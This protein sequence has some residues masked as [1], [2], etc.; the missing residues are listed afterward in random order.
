MAYSGGQFD[1]FVRLLEKLL[2][3]GRVPDA[4]LLSGRGTTSRATRY[5]R[6]SPQDRALVG[7][8]ERQV[9]SGRRDDDHGLPGCVPIRAPKLSGLPVMR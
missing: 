2:R 1:D 9:R 4:I 8:I 7:D 3:Q 5:L 6:R